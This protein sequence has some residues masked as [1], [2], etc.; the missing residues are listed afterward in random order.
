MQQFQE[1]HRYDW[2][3]GGPVAAATAIKYDDENKGWTM[4]AAEA[5]KYGNDNKCKAMKAAVA[6]ATAIKYGDNDN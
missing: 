4:T 5:I 6:T 2:W 3:N 1:T